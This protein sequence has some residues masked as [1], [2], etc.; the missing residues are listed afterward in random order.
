MNQRVD[1]ILTSYASEQARIEL[2]RQGGTNIGAAVGFV[3]ALLV[4]FGMIGVI[5]EG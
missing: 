1:Q 4:L 5:A 3:A 2:A